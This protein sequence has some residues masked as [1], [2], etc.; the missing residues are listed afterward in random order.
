MPQPIH[1]MRRRARGAP[2]SSSSS[3]RAKGGDGSD[4]YL[5]LGACSLI[6]IVVALFAAGATLT[7]AYIVT[8][9]PGCW[10]TIGSTP[11]KEYIR[12]GPAPVDPAT[13][14]DHGSVPV[15]A[16]AQDPSFPAVCTAEQLSAV[17]RQLPR[18][19]CYGE[20]FF[21]ACSFTVAT[22]GC[23]NPKLMREFYGQQKI[24]KDGDAPF[25]GVMVGWQNDDV[26]ID[27]L[28]IG[29]GD[30]KYDH[31]RWHALTKEN[32][33]GCKPPVTGLAA[34]GVQKAQ[35]LVVEW[36]AGGS[37]AALAQLK[38]DFAFTDEEMLLDTTDLGTAPDNTLSN[39]ITSKFPGENRPIHYLHVNGMGN[40]YTLLTRQM[41]TDVLK[42]VRYLA[43]EYNWK[44]T[45]A[46]SD[47]K[48]SVLLQHLK[49]KAGLVCYWS[50]S[51]SNQGLWRITDCWLD[52]YNTKHW[53][54]IVCVNTRH[55]DVSELKNRMEAN[56]LGTLKRD[57]TFGS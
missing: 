6:A 43:F 13:A 9:R 2:S 27:T 42:N 48:L 15:P 23:Q 57:Q 40:D 30:P 33:V 38:K 14:A 17:E 18:E 39:L 55:D 47:V 37:Y 41:S 53:A 51:D 25:L 56:F 21:Q 31:S 8:N 35:T 49:T 1:T 44:G 3:S 36:D 7:T 16:P 26:P 46:A 54:R 34:R 52:Y 12:T 50:G 11:R 20:A 24:I 5:T 45:W 29:S 19:S 10:T 32:N 28:Y 4:D 22:K